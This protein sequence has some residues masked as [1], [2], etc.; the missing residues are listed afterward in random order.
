MITSERPAEGWPLVAGP[1]IAWR[2]WCLSG[3]GEDVRLLPV[4]GHRRLWPPKARARAT[5]GK[6]RLHRS[7]HPECTCGLHATREPEL[8]RRTKGPTVVGLVALWGVVVEHELGYR[9]RFG[10]PVSVRLIC[11]ICFWQRGIDDSRE[12]AVVATFR[13]G[14]PMP[15]CPR[16]VATAAEADVHPSRIVPASQVLRSIIDVYEIDALP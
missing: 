8:L 5:C 9:A 2:T 10:Y 3:V 12:P 6:W 16:H 13:R 15:L 14:R 11:P 7:P 4:S 1:V